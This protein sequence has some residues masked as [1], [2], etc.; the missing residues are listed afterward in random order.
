[1]L[2]STSLAF[3]RSGEFRSLTSEYAGGGALLKKKIFRGG[4]F[5][6]N[7]FF[8]RMLR[9]NQQRLLGCLHVRRIC[10]NPAVR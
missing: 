2:L 8:G 10:P 5:F 6:I 4:R 7:I 9:I 1:M 3:F